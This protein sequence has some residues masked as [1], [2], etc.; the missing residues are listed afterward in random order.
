MASSL[1]RGSPFPA[2]G[3]PATARVTVREAWEAYLRERRPAWGPHHYR[4]H[5][6]L[7]RE[8]GQAEGRGTQGRGVTIDMPLA[9]LMPLRLQALD[10]RLLRAW[11][12]REARARPASTQLAWRLLRG[13]LRWCMRQPELQALVPPPPAALPLGVGDTP[14]ARSARATRAEALRREELGAW[15]A[16]VRQLPNPAVATALQ[17]M[18]LTGAHAR[19]ILALAWDDIDVPG[20]CLVLRDPP[21]GQRTIALTPHVHALLVALPREGALVFHSATAREGH[22]AV[23]RKPHMQACVAAGIAPLPLQGLRRSFTR[24]SEWLDVPAGVVATIQGY[25][26]SAVGEKRPRQA[27]PVELLRRHQA[28]IE[29]WMV[30][31][32]GLA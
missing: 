23:P 27:R 29:A 5:L 31:Q 13:F 6:K 28:R 11:A 2:A 15:F 12:T 14:S 9:P 1:H 30:G 32:A 25:R 21:L 26:P 24:L 3:V 17:A 8:G 16:S 22:I 4:D 10:E 19:E 7:A 20:E 18:L